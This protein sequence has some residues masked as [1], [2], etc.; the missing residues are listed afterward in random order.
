M[1]IV[2][3]ISGLIIIYLFKK[4]TSISLIVLVIAPFFIIYSVLSIFLNSYQTFPIWICGI[5]VTVIIVIGQKNKIQKIQS[6]ILVFFFVLITRFYLMPNY[7]LLLSNVENAS[8]FNFKGISFLNENGRTIKFDS[9]PNSIIVMDIWHP[10]CLPCFKTFPDLDKLR[11]RYENDKNIKIYSLK[12]PMTNG[13]ALNINELLSKYQFEKIS[14]INE[15]I[16]KKL[17]IVSVP[18][19]LVFNKQKKCIYAGSL[20]V[21][22]LINISNI[23]S[24]IE[25]N[26]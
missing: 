4:N 10:T 11:K 6:Y 19:T 5:I 1:M 9:I 12:I 26:K 7:F 20:N 3:F 25:N 22:K 21:N 14:F 15:I 8:K 24:I 16:P 17:G 23:N 13:Q 2:S 18:I